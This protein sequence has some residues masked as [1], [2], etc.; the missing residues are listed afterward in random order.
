LSPLLFGVFLIRLISGLVENPPSFGVELG[1]NL[2][3]LLLSADDLLALLACTKHQLQNIL[4]VL[5]DFCREYDLEVNVHKF[6]VILFG[7]RT[8]QGSRLCAIRKRDGRA[9][10]QMPMA[11]EFR[12]L[13]VIFHATKRESL[14]VA[15]PSLTIAV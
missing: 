14:H 1:G 8:Y 9:R 5:A 4:R 13:A 3:Q 15:I 10:Q 12:F 11:E 2:L 6:A 7:K